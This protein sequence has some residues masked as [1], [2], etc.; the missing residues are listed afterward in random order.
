MILQQENEK[1]H[2]EEGDDFRKIGVSQRSGNGFA[3]LNE[4]L[5]G[6]LKEKTEQKKESKQQNIQEANAWERTKLSLSSV[7]KQT[8]KPTKESTCSGLPTKITHSNE[9]NHNT[10]HAI[11]N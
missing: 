9:R 1:R 10:V 4:Q 3:R 6:Q 5:H 7:R 8:V 11:K 2:T